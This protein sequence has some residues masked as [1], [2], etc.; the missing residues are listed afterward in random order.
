VRSSVRQRKAAKKRKEETM[1]K[2]L[3]A[4]VMFILVLLWTWYNYTRP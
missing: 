4:G 3:I 1:P 2:L